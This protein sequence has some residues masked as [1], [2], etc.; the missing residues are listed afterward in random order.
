MIEEVQSGERCGVRECYPPDCDM[1]KEGFDCDLLVLLIVLWA[2]K[3]AAP[4]VVH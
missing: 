2:W 4:A 1:S 3:K